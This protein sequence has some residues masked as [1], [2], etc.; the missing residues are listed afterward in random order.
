MQLWSKQLECYK[1]A[2]TKSYKTEALETNC[3]VLLNLK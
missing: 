2:G 1:G 3:K